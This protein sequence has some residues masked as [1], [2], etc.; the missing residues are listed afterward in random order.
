MTVEQPCHN[1]T[2]QKSPRAPDQLSH[3]GPEPL[4]LQPRAEAVNSQQPPPCPRPCRAGAVPATADH[5]AMAMAVLGVLLLLALPLLLAAGLYCCYVWRVHA[6]YDHI[7]SA[8]R[9]R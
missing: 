6:A 1:H 7:P 4:L 8:P 9:E 5:R 2:I 3:F